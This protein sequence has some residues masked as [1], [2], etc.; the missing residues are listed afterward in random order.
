MGKNKG[1]GLFSRTCLEQRMYG[2]L[3]GFGLKPN[4]RSGFIE[5][6]PTRS[7]FVLDFA[8]LDYHLDFETDGAQWHNSPKQRKR[9]S[10]RDH[11]HK[12]EGWKTIRFPEYFDKDDVEKVLIEHNVRFN[13]FE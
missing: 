9:D 7:G 13:R 11:Q 12:I 10:F 5:Q 8:L 6:Y 1:R 3:I 4:S 2:Y